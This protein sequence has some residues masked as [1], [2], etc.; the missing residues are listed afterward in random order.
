MFRTSRN[1]S[2]SRNDT[3]PDLQLIQNRLLHP[4]LHIEI[5]KSRIARTYEYISDAFLKQSY[6]NIDKEMLNDNIMP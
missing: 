3:L 5:R 4:S 6:I 1:D 2:I